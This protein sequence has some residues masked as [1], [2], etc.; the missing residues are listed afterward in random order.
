MCNGDEHIFSHT[1]RWGDY[2]TIETPLGTTCDCGAFYWDGE[3]A[4]PVERDDPC[5]DC[6]ALPQASGGDWCMDCPWLI[7]WDAM[8]EGTHLQPVLIPERALEKMDNRMLIQQ[9]FEIMAAN[10]KGR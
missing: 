1:R 3:Q 8:K 6:Y 4:Q 9:Q 10:N 5:K 7:A 2:T